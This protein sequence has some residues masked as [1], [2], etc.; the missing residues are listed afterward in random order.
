[1]DQK[2]KSYSNKTELALSALMFFA[3][4]IQNL[5]KKNNIE[6]SDQNFLN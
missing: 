5:M 1:M 6:K 3:P 2:H 4:L